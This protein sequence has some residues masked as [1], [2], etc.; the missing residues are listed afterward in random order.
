MPTQATPR[1]LLEEKAPPRSLASAAQAPLTR[2]FVRAGRWTLWWADKLGRARRIVFV[3][4][5]APLAATCAVLAVVFLKR[6]M[7]WWGA[8]AAAA[9]VL[10]T[11]GPPVFYAHRR[12]MVGDF[13]EASHKSGDAKPPPVDIGNL[14][15]TELSRFGSLFRVVENRRAVPSG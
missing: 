11:L 8:A 2:I 10:L 1:D 6:D 12:V 3:D 15:Q 7:D 13:G 14:L 4:G 9:A 5:R